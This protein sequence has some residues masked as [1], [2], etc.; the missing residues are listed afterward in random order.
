VVVVALVLFILFAAVCLAARIAWPGLTVA[1]ELPVSDRRDGTRP[2][3]ADDDPD[4][5]RRLGR[6]TDPGR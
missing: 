3:G 6:R 1:A 2:V 5:L 4:F